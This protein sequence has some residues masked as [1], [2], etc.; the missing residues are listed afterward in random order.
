MLNNDKVQHACRRGPGSRSKVL[1]VFS[2]TRDELFVQRL[3]LQDRPPSLVH[4]I[5]HDG[6]RMIVWRGAPPRSNACYTYD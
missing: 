2:K 6:C 3:S 5:A 1:R 4:E